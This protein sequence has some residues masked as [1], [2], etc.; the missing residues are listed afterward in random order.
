MAW[1]RLRPG[2]PVLSPAALRT[3]ATGTLAAFKIRRY[4][5]AIEEFPIPASG[6]VRKVALRQMAVD[7]LR[8][9]RSWPP[10]THLH[11][12]RTSSPARPG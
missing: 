8:S 7:L 2:A 11:P 5:T 9:S 6:K 10:S 3:F 1:V 4:V 12:A